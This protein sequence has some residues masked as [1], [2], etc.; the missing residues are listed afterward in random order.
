MSGWGFIAGTP[1]MVL[2]LCAPTM[3]ACVAAM[4][5]AEFFLFINTGPM[6]T[7]VV[8]VTKAGTRAMAFAINIFMIH[9]LGDAI[10]PAIIGHLSDLY[11]LKSALFIT[12]GMIVL[13]AALCFACMRYIERDTAEAKDQVSE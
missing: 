13:A 2:A 7:I 8:N 9:A 6:N 12:P 1:L 11:G 5:A 4:F 3:Q 10:S